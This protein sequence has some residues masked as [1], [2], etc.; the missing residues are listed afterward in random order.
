MN[1]KR[2]IGL[3]AGAT[4]T[5]FS[6]V[7]GGASPADAQP[8]FVAPATMLPITNI[9]ERYLSYNVEMAEVIGGKFWKPYDTL[10]K[11]AAQ[12]AAPVSGPA[13]PSSGG[14]DAGLQAG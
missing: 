13:A 1:K 6:A 10:G 12:H 7:L 4:L 2:T 9:D 3:C 8:V 11:A 14:T 5:S